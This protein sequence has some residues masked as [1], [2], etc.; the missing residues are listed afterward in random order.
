MVADE[1]LAIDV[2]TANSDPGSICQL[3]VAIYRQGRLVS[4]MG[5]LVDCGQEFAPANVSVHG[6]DHNSMGGAVPLTGMLGPLAGLLKGRVVAQ[7][8][9]FDQRSIETACAACGLEPPKA[10]WIDTAT[11]ARRTWESVSKKGYGLGD[12]CQMIGHMNPKPHDAEQDAI[13]CGAVLAAICE[14][15][16]LSASELQVMLA[17]GDR[18][19]F[20]TKG[21]NL[22]SVERPVTYSGNS[23]G[24]LYGE[25]VCITGA[26]SMERAAIAAMANEAGCKVT[27]SVSKKTTVLVLGD[28]GGPTGKTK[29]ADELIAAGHTL[30]ILDEKDFLALLDSAR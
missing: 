12:L 6:I 24:R 19:T 4:S 22:A 10:L 29:K 25:V 20:F 8:T 28:T 13:A 14:T 11:A 9:G 17:R 7:H 18:S 5:K 1:Y 16:R 15:R 3:G 23:N 26:L 27:S 21:G 2:E 30:R